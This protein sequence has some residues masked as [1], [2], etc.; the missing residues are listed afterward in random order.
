VALY[1]AVFIFFAVSLRLVVDGFKIKEELRF[2]GIVGAV[3]VIPWIL[4]NLAFEDVFYP[5]LSQS[6]L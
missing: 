2:T 1:V 6:N 3:A 4:F 5:T